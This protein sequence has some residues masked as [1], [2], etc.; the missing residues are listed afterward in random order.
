MGAMGA[1][2][3]HDGFQWPGSATTFICY[4][5]SI[6][7]ATMV[8]YTCHLTGCLVPMLD[9]SKRFL[10]YG[11]GRNPARKQMR[12]LSTWP[13]LKKERSN[14]KTNKC[15]FNKLLAQ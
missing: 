10:P 11:K 2:L 5:I 8:P 7:T 3:G 15:S 6:L 12:L 9:P 1:W 14:R 4:T 13:V